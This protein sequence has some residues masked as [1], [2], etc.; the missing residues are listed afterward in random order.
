MTPKPLYNARD[1]TPAYQLRYTWCGWPSHDSFE[2][3]PA[4]IWDSLTSD[5]EGD[6]LRRLERTAHGDHILLTFSTT[7]AVSPVLLA[8]KT[9][10]RLQHAFG[11]AGF[12]SVQFSRKLAVRSVG[13]NTT[14]AVHHY[15][16]SQVETA[17]FVDS[18]FAEI[19]SQFTTTD[20]SVD[21]SQP[22]ESNSGRYWYNLH[23]VLV[24]EGR[25]RLVDESALRILHEGVPKIAAKKGFRVAAVSVM[26]DHLNV[27][28][29][30]S[31]EQSP[32]EIA[33]ACQNN[34]AFMVN[35]GPIWRPGYYVGTFG[36]YD[37]DAIRH[38]VRAQSASPVT[39]GHGGRR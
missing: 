28:L 22:S 35:R 39:Q 36:E 19:L 23:L 17:G 25:Y 34:L 24:T 4:G 27:A 11:E 9:K 37:M 20:D 26:P 33:L 21:L 2:E 16:D 14:R 1:Q 10:G 15:I 30:G 32:E 7:P 8:K 13:D 38:L 31:I 18:S 3:L 29:R 5:W 12:P 6:G